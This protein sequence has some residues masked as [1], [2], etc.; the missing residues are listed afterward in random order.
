MPTEKEVV[1]SSLV[2]KAQYVYLQAHR[3]AGPKARD[4]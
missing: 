2:R 1:V 3:E 4:L